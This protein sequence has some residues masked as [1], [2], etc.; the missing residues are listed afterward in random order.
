MME[1]YTPEEAWEELLA[2]RRAYYDQYMAAFS[3]DHGH[4]SRTAARGSFWKRGGKVKLHVPAAA[5]I[6]GT[7]ANML[8]GEE[9]RYAIYDESLGNT[10]EGSQGRLEAIIAGNGLNRKL[11]EAAEGGAAAGDVFLK[12]RYDRDNADMP[13]I[14]V[15]R[16]PDALPEYRM[17]RLTRIHFFTVLKA[18]RKNGR[19]WRVY[20][21]YEPGRIL[22]AVYCG[23]STALGTE[24]PEM[25]E[26]LALEEETATPEGLLLAA[27]IANLKPSRIWETDDKGRSDFEGLRDLMD[28]LD[29]IYT[30][31]LR[32]I[33]LAKSRLIVPAE[34][35][36]RNPSDLFREGSYT[37]DFD[38]D[39]ETLVALD[40]G[41]DGVEMKIT[42]SQFGIRAAEHAQTY[43][44]TLRAI[45]SMAGY[46][47]QTFGLD[48]QGSA[49][50]GTARRIMERKSL[51]TNAKKQSYWKAPLE[52]FLT[53]VMHLDKALYG[54][55]NLHADDSVRVEMRDPAMNDL[56]ETA[57]AVSLLRSA[58][59]ASTETLVRM[60]HS[61]WTERQVQEEAQR[62]FQ[63]NSGKERP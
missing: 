3:G 12:C 44:T 50:S 14:D 8:F 19:V 37:Y 11:L 9:P 32:D 46:S 47:P 35:L 20:E 45:V 62:I 49:Q 53:A 61:D 40:I 15:V 25:L 5:D 6:A 57:G 4:L 10:E 33:R 29:E 26:E 21:R 41:G 42:P 22:T 56:A 59:A 54:N 60:L 48:I 43:E 52:A 51:S 1:F 38:E 34:F 18:E 24:K 13:V 17:N 28:S 23:D 31:W 39:V 58:Q 27:H 16:G 36:R 2:R 63:Q 7:A 30:S 55:D